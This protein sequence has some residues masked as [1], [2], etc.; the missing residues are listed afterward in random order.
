VAK[1]AIEYTN[2][3]EDLLQNLKDDKFMAAFINDAASD[4]DPDEFLRALRW[5]ILSRGG[6]DEF[7]E[8][9]ELGKSSLYRMLDTDGNPRLS[10]IRA[11]LDSLGLKIRVDAA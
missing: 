6:F 11:V 5:V 7:A 10:S 2:F 4:E 8:R 3:E 9:T 1:N